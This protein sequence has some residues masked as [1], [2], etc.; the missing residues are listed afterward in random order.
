[1]ERCYNCKI[2]VCNRKT[3]TRP[4]L[5]HGNHRQCFNCRTV[6][7]HFQN[8][9]HPIN[10][11]RCKRNKTLFS[12]SMNPSLEVPPIILSGNRVKEI[13]QQ[14]MAWVEAKNEAAW[15]KAKRTPPIT[16]KNVTSSVFLQ[17]KNMANVSFM[18]PHIS[19]MTTPAFGL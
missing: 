3:C 9:P 5:I 11:A 14:R 6:G 16:S 1:M 15:L 10:K 4:R 2:V 12:T 17:K 7:C 19:G 18:E 8:C 13:N